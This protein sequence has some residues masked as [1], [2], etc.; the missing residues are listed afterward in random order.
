MNKDELKEIL[1]CDKKTLLDNLSVI[2]QMKL[3]L[4]RH[5]AWLRWKYVK[6]MRLSVESHSFFLRKIYGCK[7]LRLGIKLNYEISPVA[8]IG[9]GLMIYHN[10]PIVINPNVVAGENLVLHGDNCIGNSG[11]DQKCPVIGN[12]VELGY[13]A[14]IIGDVHIGNNICIGAGAVVVN[15]FIEDGITIVGVPARKI[16]G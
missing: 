15:D 11:K 9:K 4:R 8:K 13:G 10:G 6:S 1:A 3:C 7:Y 16:T 14:K 2:G 12:N 5:P